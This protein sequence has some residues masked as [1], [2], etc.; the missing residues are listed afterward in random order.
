[1]QPNIINKYHYKA[2]RMTHKNYGDNSLTYIFMIC[3]YNVLNKSYN[4]LKNKQL[5]NQYL[6]VM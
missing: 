3:M 1:M 4:E 2:L 6:K 5:G